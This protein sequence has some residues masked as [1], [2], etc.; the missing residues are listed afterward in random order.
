MVDARREGPRADPEQEFH[1]WADFGRAAVTVEQINGW[2]LPTRPTKDTDTR[3]R[4]FVGDSVEL[5][6]IPADDLRSLV[7][8]VIER[9]VDQHQ[10]TVLRTVEAEERKVFMRMAKTFNGGADR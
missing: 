5:D 1:Y 9:H 3:A 8:E 4:K 6:A 10:L 7:R 2:D